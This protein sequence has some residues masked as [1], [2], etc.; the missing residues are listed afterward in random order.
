MSNYRIARVAC[1]RGYVLFCTQ[2]V[3]VWM[4]EIM[5]NLMKKP[6]LPPPAA[7]PLHRFKPPSSPPIPASGHVSHPWPCTTRLACLSRDA[8]SRTFHVHLPTCLHVIPRRR[9][10][11][12]PRDVGSRLLRGRTLSSRENGSQFAAKP[13]DH[14][15][16]GAGAAGLGRKWEEVR[17]RNKC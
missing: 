17:D 10:Y 11:R 15:T 6:S 3:S 8:P 2:L 7:T 16:A 14:S 12:A 4:D 1:R 9:K 13:C 5:D